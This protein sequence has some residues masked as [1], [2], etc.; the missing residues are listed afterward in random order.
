MTTINKVL[1]P[2][3]VWSSI[4]IHFQMSS[5]ITLPNFDRNTL[6]YGALSEIIH[7]P[8][9]KS[10]ILSNLSSIDY[11]DFFEEISNLYQLKF[12]KFDEL[13]AEGYD[14]SEADIV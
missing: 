2:M 5:N 11:Q 8:E 6:L 1:Q 3:G 9:L 7:H 4:L 13:H 12:S 14:P 10:I